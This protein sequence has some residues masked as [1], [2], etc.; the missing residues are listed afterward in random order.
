MSLTHKAIPFEI[1]EVDEEGRTFLAVASTEDEDRDGDR[2]MA[3]GWNLENFRKN[4]VIPWVHRYSD[5]P[6]AQAVDVFVE[7]KKL[8]FRPKFASADEYPF[9][10]TIFKLYKGGFLRSFSVG[11]DPKRHEVVDRGKGR[12]GY[13]FLEQ[14]LWEISAV[15]VPSNPNALVAAAKKGVINEDEAEAAREAFEEKKTEDGRRKTEEKTDPEDPASPEEI[16]REI[17]RHETVKTAGEWL[18]SA[19][20]KGALLKRLDDMETRL[21][22]MER[23]AGQEHETADGGQQAEVGPAEPGEDETRTGDSE[24][25]PALINAAVAAA[26]KRLGGM[27]ESMIEKKLGIVR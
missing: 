21:A 3:D 16:E 15:T 8:M 10:D 9:A 20:E 14:E 27:V 7:G 6:V 12:R 24:E 11:F 25:V 23:A 19:M 22:A 4:P 17:D 13:D 5:P 26:A 1:K 2:I 18:S